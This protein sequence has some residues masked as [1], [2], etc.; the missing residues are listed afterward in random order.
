MALLPL[1]GCG[2]SDVLHETS[3]EGKIIPALR[4]VQYRDG[5]YDRF[6]YE[7]IS[8]GNP[9]LADEIK[10][11]P[12]AEGPMQ[13][14]CQRLH[15]I[16]LIVY[17]DN[18]WRHDFDFI[19]TWPGSVETAPKHFTYEDRWTHGYLQ[20]ATRFREPLFDGL[21]TLSVTHRREKIYSTEFQI[22]GC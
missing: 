16:G 11:T 15:E 5:E 18:S 21:I 10:N 1:G 19:A 4:Y 3:R 22:V 14:D 17:R 7:D 9:D 13:V 2:L 8:E 6:V 20:G 12:V